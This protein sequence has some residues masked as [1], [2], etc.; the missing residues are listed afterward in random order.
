M[1]ADLVKR[2]ETGHLVNLQLAPQE[3]HEEPLG[4]LDIILGCSAILAYQ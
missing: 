2:I 3:V 4:D 1:L